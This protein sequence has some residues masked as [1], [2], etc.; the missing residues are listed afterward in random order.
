ML[1]FSLDG[2]PMAGFEHAG[3][4]VAESSSRSTWGDVA[5][6]NG[7]NPRN[8]DVAAHD[9]AASTWSDVGRELAGRAG[10]T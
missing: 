6:A 2:R 4:P 1:T 8:V 10:S 3:G 7:S 9:N 5:R